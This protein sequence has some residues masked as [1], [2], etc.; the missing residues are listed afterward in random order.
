MRTEVDGEGGMGGVWGFEIERVY[1]LLRDVVEVIRCTPG[2]EVTNVRG[3]FGKWDGIHVWFS[4]RG[5]GCV[6]AEPYGDS[7]RY[8]IGPEGDAL[9]DLTE[10]EGQF[11][12]YSPPLWLWFVGDLLSLRV[13]L[14]RRP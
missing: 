9:V 3:A 6:V 8:W 10:L 14:L 4:F 7:S 2:A 12:Q 13:P 1:I 5:V 11:S